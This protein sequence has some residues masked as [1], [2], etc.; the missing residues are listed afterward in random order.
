MLSKKVL[1][2]M[3]LDSD[4]ESRIPSSSLLE[5]ILPEMMLE[6]DSLR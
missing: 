5:T 4:E 1:R 3:L 2:E 6:S